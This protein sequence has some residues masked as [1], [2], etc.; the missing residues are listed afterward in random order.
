MRTILEF[1]LIYTFK[2]ALWLRYRVEIRGLDKLNQE[3]LNKPG[4]ILFLPNHPTVFVDPTLVTLAVW[5]KFPI[6]PMIVEY[7]Y[8]TPFVNWIMRL[9]NAIP[10][11]NFTTTSN[12]LKRRKSERVMEEVAASL[13][14][15]QNFLVYPAGKTKSTNYESIG[16]ASGVHRILSDT[17]EANVV[18]VRTSGLWGSSFSRAFT[19]KSPPLIPTVLQGVKTVFKNLIFFSP[20]RQVIIEFQP[21]PADFPLKASRLELNK[22]LETWFNKPDGL[23]VQKGDAP[24]DSL[25]MVSLSMWGEKYPQMVQTHGLSEENIPSPDQIPKE[26]QDKVIAKLAEITEYDPVNIK[27]SMELSSDLGLDSLDTAELIIFLQDE[28]DITGVPVNELTTVNK[29]MAIASRQIVCKEEIEEE[30]KD[31]SKWKRSIVRERRYLPDGKIMPEVFLNSCERMGNFPACGDSRA[32]VLSYP[33]LKM[34]VLV[35]AEHIRHLPGEYIGILLPSSV[36][37]TVLIFATQL[38]GKV[39]LLINWTV[40]P[41]HLDTVVRLSDVKVILSSWSFLDKLENVD[42]DIL[43][44]KLVMLEDVRNQITLTSKLKSLYL[45]KLSPQKVLKAFNIHKLSPDHQAVLLFTSGTENLPKGVP[46]SHRN[47]LTNQKAALE[48]VEIFSD[49]ILFGIL[50]P[51]HSF[52]FTVSS[53]LALLGGLRVAYFPNPTDGKRLADNFAHWKITIMCGAPTFIK[54]MLRAARPQQLETMRVCITGAEKAPQDLFDMIDNLGKGKILIEGYGITECSPILTFNPLG[55]TPKGVGIPLP[56]VEICIVHQET[57]EPLPVNTQGLILAKGQNIFSGYLGPNL[58]SPFCDIKGERWY[59]TGDLG[60]LDEEGNL[61]IS[62]RMKR[63]I[64][65]GGEMLSLASIE[66]ALLQIAG[67]KGWPIDPEGPSLAVCAKEN[68]GEKTKIFLFTKF[69]TTVDDTNRALKEAG[70]SNLV[71][72]SNVTRVNEIP[73]MGTGKI[74]YRKLESTINQK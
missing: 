33:Q 40:G 43:E 25:V 14:K 23:T 46:L 42:L 30:E 37:A 48:A 31:I 41:R 20:R 10:V 66:E 35:M 45:S 9:L 24:G 50:P 47:L 27:P 6:R 38:A 74:N 34:R 28:F 64:K 26:V 72:I 60:F 39:P 51:F 53:T 3:N 59:K 5:N 21:A 69:D 55:K 52:G 11:P 13:K 70:F 12:S 22:Y 1:L 63:F 17:P 19:G 67:K 49:D 4:G 73:L 54:G 68:G 16:G 29:L 65:I 8:Y 2:F 57:M 62:G 71:K 15:G 56:G 7:M 36:A 58:V 18:L 32:G 44:D 61:T